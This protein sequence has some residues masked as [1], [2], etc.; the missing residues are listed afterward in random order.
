MK[1]YEHSVKNAK[2]ERKCT[3]IMNWKRGRGG[4]VEASMGIDW[5]TYWDTA[6]RRNS[7]SEGWVGV[8]KA[9]GG[10]EEG[11][12]GRGRC[13]ESRETVYGAGK[14]VKISL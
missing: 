12:L 11:Y 14:K 2:N 7:E 9:R 6:P 13:W 10:G 5:G 3:K 4:K 8:G 1:G